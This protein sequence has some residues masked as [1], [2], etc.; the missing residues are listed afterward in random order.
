MLD[1]K[2]LKKMGADPGMW[3]ATWGGCGLI[4]SAP[5]TWGT[6]GGLPVGVALLSYG[7]WAELL[8]AT[9]ILFW[10]GW[11]AARRFEEVTGEHDSGAV[12]VDEVV[13]VWLALLSAPLT[14][15]GVIAAF[16]LFRFFDI[17]KP[18]PVNKL[19]ELPGPTGVMA[20]DIA[21]GIYT[22]IWLLVLHHVG[23]I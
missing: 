12:V 16:V 2:L 18:W 1:K 22:A 13:G 7:G 14:I 4:K 8:C 15:Q 20:D 21:A 10:F 11:K 6:L 19:D 3:L 9:V 23:L 17:L 5:G